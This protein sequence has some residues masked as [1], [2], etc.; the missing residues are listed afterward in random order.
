M[1][2]RYHHTETNQAY[3]IEEKYYAEE[4]GKLDGI[5]RFLHEYSGKMDTLRKNKTY[6]KNQIK[7]KAYSNDKLLQE[8]YNLYTTYVTRERLSEFKRDLETDIVEKRNI[9]RKLQ[10]S[11]PVLEKLKP[12]NVAVQKSKIQRLQNE[13]QALLNLQTGNPIVNYYVYRKIKLTNEGK[14]ITDPL[15]TTRISELNIREDARQRRTPVV[16]IIRNESEL[17]ELTE[18][19]TKAR[20]E[21]P[22]VIKAQERAAAAK[23]A[24]EEKA[25]REATEKEAK[26]AAFFEAASI[27]A[28]TNKK[29]KIQEAVKGINSKRANAEAKAKV[30]AE[31]A[32]AEAK[33]QAEAAEAEAKAKAEAE[34]AE[35]EAKAKAEAEAAEAEAKAKAE[36]EAARAEAARVEAANN[37]LIP[38]NQVP[39]IAAALASPVKSRFNVSTHSPGNEPKF[40]GGAKKKSKKNKKS[41]KIKKG[42]T[43]LKKSRK[44]RTNKKRKSRKN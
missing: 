42:K 11:I 20:K 10:E 13:L 14:S 41:K 7:W 43:L 44:V 29:S 39:K 30:E 6:G 31:A 22:E 37:S 17:P 9:I 1:P 25:A 3:N 40:N 16:T 19:L 2:G 32:E 15:M 35:A 18:E 4:I 28:N 34:A 24:A 12:E 33:A 5:I 36:A 26:K 27:A 38:H 8:R 23:K 21:R